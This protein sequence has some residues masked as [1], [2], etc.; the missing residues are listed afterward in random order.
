MF[1]DRSKKEIQKWEEQMKGRA[2]QVYKGDVDWEG[3]MEEAGIK[4]GKKYDKMCGFFGGKIPV[5]DFPWQTVLDD[6]QFKDM[7][8]ETKRKFYHSQDALTKHAAIKKLAFDDKKKL[9]EFKGK[10]KKKQVKLSE[11]DRDLL[12]WED[13][14]DYQMTRKEFVDRARA[15]AISTFAVLKDGKW[16]EKGEMGW[17]AI[18]SNEKDRGDWLREYQDLVLGLPDDTLLT[19][20][21]CHI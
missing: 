17:W 18:V 7:D 19:V 9:L 2:D 21:D 14:A 15:G 12:I 4:A 16:Y 10:A 8:I 6:K 13:L 3:M 20:A 1:M 5:I 11:K